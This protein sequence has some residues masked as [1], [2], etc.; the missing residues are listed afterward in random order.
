MEVD[1]RKLL[2]KYISHV[3]DC[4][5]VDFINFGDN[6]GSEAKF[7]KEEWEILQAISDQ[8]KPWK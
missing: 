3:K 2:E 8:D 5:G 4:E 1:Y 6:T 7:S